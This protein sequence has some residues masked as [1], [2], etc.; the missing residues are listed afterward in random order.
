VEQSA[1]AD[2][3][4]V[5]SSMVPEETGHSSPVI[6]TPQA[7]PAPDTTVG[8][9]FPMSEVWRNINPHTSSGTTSH[10]DEGIL[11][12]SKHSTASIATSN[13]LNKYESRVFPDEYSILDDALL[14]CTPYIVNTKYKV[15]VCTEC[16]R[17]VIPNRASEHLHIHHS[18]CKVGTG[19][20]ERL[21]VRFPELVA[22]VV[23]P[24]EVIEAIFGLA[25]PDKKYIICRRCRRGYLNIESW[26]HHK[27]RNA[28]ADLAGLSEHFSSLVQT[29]FHGPRMCYF[30]VRLPV[31]ASDE[32]HRN[33]FDLFKSSFKEL[34]L[35]E[36]E[37]HEPEDYREVNQFLL[38]EG[39]IKHISG[40]SPSEL[41]LLTVPPKEDDILKPVAR[42]VIALMSNIQSAIGMAGYFVR[43]LLGR[44][45][46][47][48]HF[49]FSM[50]QYIAD[51]P[52]LSVISEYLD[53]ACCLAANCHTLYS[54]NSIRTVAH[55]DVRYESLKKYALIVTCLISFVF[56]CFE[57]W[58]CNYPMKLT[59]A[60]ERACQRLREVLV[61]QRASDVEDDTGLFGEGDVFGP[62][63]DE[64]EHLYNEE[65]EDL[66]EDAEES[67]KVQPD[68]VEN[69][70]QCSI[71][72]L[73]ISLYTHLPSGADDKFYSPI[74]RFLVLFS[75]TR[76]GQWHAGRRI[77]Q[78]F[79]AVLF[80]GREMM[81]A[82]M[83][84]EVSQGSS[85]RYSE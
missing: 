51:S 65:Y 29:F 5:E 77:S 53:K 75:V 59:V 67:M 30:P 79:A 66:E 3:A 70:V 1:S 27:C 9:E 47:Y 33:D 8:E 44:Q 18:H 46:T 42:N 28:D 84:R 45:P 17:C 14:K 69:P 11:T 82:V 38:K 19:F 15:L 71:L 36:D 6:A 83:H 49:A 40:C 64:L 13:P 73:L 7:F 23:H 24:Q 16:R 56:R 57:G 22:E 4:D 63:D 54:H 62:D 34:A 74:F 76:N 26:R 35:S 72:D 2:A 43:R 39:W 25:I 21:C 20:C 52:M 61:E 50:P 37:I 10:S 48:V 68:F 31:S 32:V 58:E 85:V 80:C 60:Q 55:R 81:M 78:W 12:T 41:S